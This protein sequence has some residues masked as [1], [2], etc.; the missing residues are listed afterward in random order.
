MCFTVG[1]V[2]NAILLL[3]ATFKLNLQVSH[4]WSTLYAIAGSPS[5]LWGLEFGRFRVTMGF[6]AFN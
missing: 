6:G 3:V 2:I 4:A 5:R 1:E